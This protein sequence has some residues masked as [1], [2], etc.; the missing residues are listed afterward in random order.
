MSNPYDQPGTDRQLVEPAVGGYYAQPYGQTGPNNYPD[1]NYNNNAGYNQ[2]NA[3]TQPN[4]QYQQPQYQQTPPQ[5]Q[6]PPPA[7]IVVNEKKGLQ[8]ECPYCHKNANTVGKYTVGCAAWSWGLVLLFT[9]GICCW[10]PCVVDDCK[11]F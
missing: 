6:Q 1:I 5:Y 9:T 10:I 8:N 11:D 4:Q 3:Y 7:V 2:N